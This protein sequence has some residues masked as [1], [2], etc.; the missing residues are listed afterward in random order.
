MKEI[1]AR[2]IIKLGAYMFQETLVPRVYCE[3]PA[4]DPESTLLYYFRK[5][6]NGELR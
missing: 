4:I 2:L 6:L 1:I 5:L 3:T